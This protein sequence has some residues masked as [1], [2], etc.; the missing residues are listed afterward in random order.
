MSN[1]NEQTMLK[2]YLGMGEVIITADPMIIW[3]ILGSCVSIT[4]FNKRLGLAAICYAQL[5][6]KEHSNGMR[7]SDTCPKPCFRN[8]KGESTKFLSCAFNLMLEK[9]KSNGVIN[10]EMSAG[11]YGGASMFKYI[12]VYREKSI[13]DQNVELAYRLCNRNKIRVV[14]DDTGGEVGRRLKFNTLNGKI[15]MHHQNAYLGV[16]P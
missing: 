15:E 1:Q 5:P 2:K 6:E 3:T 10:N 11:I 4:L 7:C 13:G 14:D 16:N 9:F 12:Y 8:D